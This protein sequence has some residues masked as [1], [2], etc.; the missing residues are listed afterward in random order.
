[1]VAATLKKLGWWL[2]LI[3]GVV[4]SIWL[5]ISPHEPATHK[6][7]AAA[8]NALLSMP[9][10]VIERISIVDEQRAIWI[11]RGQNSWSVGSDMNSL[12][13]V[14]DAI[15]QLIDRKRGG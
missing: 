5:S 8:G 7:H 3:V 13:T 9:L 6:T 4:A 14:D 1:M 10:A 15:K 2:L 12:A 11:V